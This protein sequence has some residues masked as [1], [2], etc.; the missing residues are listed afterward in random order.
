MGSASSSS[1]FRM[2]FATR[3]SARFRAMLLVTLM[4]AYT[5]S[6]KSSGMGI[7]AME[8]LGSSQ[9]AAVRLAYS[10]IKRFNAVL[11]GRPMCVY[12]S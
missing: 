1:R 12:S 2:S 7:F 5:S 8:L 9:S 11:F 10:R 6:R 3:P 4:V